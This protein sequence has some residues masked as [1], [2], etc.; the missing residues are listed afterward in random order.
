MKPL[1]ECIYRICFASLIL[2]Y[3]YAGGDF[4]MPPYCSGRVLI[5]G[6][7]RSHISATTREELIQA[8][9][10]GNY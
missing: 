4:G 5:D 8:F 9:I 3:E 6:N 2:D 10:N 7:F 1:N